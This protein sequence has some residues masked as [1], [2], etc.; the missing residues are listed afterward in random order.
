MKPQ[1]TS[2]HLKHT[3]ELTL[4]APLRSDFVAVPDVMSYTTRLRLVLGTLNDLRRVSIER[5]EIEN[6]GALERLRSLHDVRWSIVNGE[7]QLLLAVTFDRSWEAYIQG[8]V[9]MAGPLLDMIFSHCEGYGEGSRCRD[10][11]LA[12]AKWARDHQVESQFFYAGSPGVTVD[13]IRYFVQQ[14]REPGRNPSD[15]V[16][17]DPTDGGTEVSGYNALSALHELT[18]WFPGRREDKDSDRSLW[19][20]AARVTIPKLTRLDAGSLELNAERVWLREL[21]DPPAPDN[22]ARDLMRPEEVEKL[23]DAVQA[24]VLTKVEATHGLMVLVRLNDAQAARKFLEKVAATSESETS[25]ADVAINIGFTW[26]GLERLDLPAET[27]LEVPK[28]FREGMQA[29]AGLLGD[30]G[31]NSPE[32]WE[33]PRRNYPAGI[34]DGESF[35]LDLV[36]A[37]LILQGKAA[38][39]PNDHAWTKKHPFHAKLTKLLPAKSSGVEVLHVHALR[40]YGDGGH[41][42]FA[43]GT[44]QP[45]PDVPGLNINVPQRDRVP[46]GE[47]V[48]GYRGAR[49]KPTGPVSPF[50]KNGSFLVIRK[51][52]QNVAAFEEFAK[53]NAESLRVPPDQ[54]ASAILGRDRRTGRPLAAPAENTNDFDYENDATGT[55]CPFH[56]HIRRANP[57]STDPNMRTTIP[58]IL[59]RGFTYGSKLADISAANDGDE[60]GLVFMAYNANIANQ[61][62]VV[63]RWINGGNSTG[64]LSAYTDLF[65]GTLPANPNS[66]WIHVGT[67]VEYLRPPR[68]QLVTVRWGLYV[69]VPSLEILAQIAKPK[70][71]KQ[72]AQQVKDDPELELGREILRKLGVPGEAGAWKKVLEDLGLPDQRRALWQA[73]RNEDPPVIRTDYGVLV[74]RTADVEAV[75]SDDGTNFSVE[76]YGSRMEGSLGL[77]HLG[78]D[79]HDARYATLARRPNAFA[80]KFDE[81]EAFKTTYDVAMEI[82]ERSKRP[83]I[84]VERF[85]K[86]VFLTLISTWFGLPDGERSMLQDDFLA[87]SKFVFQ[88]RPTDVL[89][90]LGTEGGNRLAEA[91]FALTGANAAKGEFLAE[92][93]RAGVPHVE[94]DTAVKSLASGLFA[95]TYGTFLAAIDPWIESGKLWRLPKT[96]SELKKE[97]L[98][99]LRAKQGPVVLY[100]ICKRK[101]TL[102][103]GPK[104][105]EVVPGDRIVLGIGSAANDDPNSEFTW[106]FGG[107]Y[108]KQPHACPA[109]PMAIGMMLGLTKAI[110][111]QFNLR[112]VRRFLLT[113]EVRPKKESETAAPKPKAKASNVRKL[114]PPSQQTSRKNRSQKRRPAARKSVAKASVKA[115]SRRD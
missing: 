72:A 77:Q 9:D 2:R 58:R 48:L 17:S 73:I 31:G 32:L 29:R 60:R 6:A 30:T 19:D 64:T 39:K 34:R 18:R 22:E 14:S 57:R 93:I 12:F 61:F 111:V 113:F 7:R 99:A 68:E 15:I 13:D 10:G 53:D 47:F 83:V 46:L 44:S 96:P 33:R 115:R 43:D 100:R 65:S 23:R 112:R 20:A 104:A 94:R 50:F 84:H 38:A 98:R 55:R 28:E 16:V 59:R 62:E 11:Y 67:T 36:D 92:L 109:Q 95:A 81:S 63:Q 42:G 86:E 35:P 56:A 27:L 3:T 80:A 79:A 69:F 114:V 78:I 21:Q 1:A 66:H 89:Q 85:A 97:L 75:L 101:Q 26:A 41:F 5:Y 70:Q 87:N 107:S 40:R 52:Q 90:R 45:V 8:I 51:L 49:P 4:L 110:L 37:V 25:L 24:N 102:G 105:I 103:Q 74:S 82:I 108:Q 91:Y 54:I 88:P 76:E 106:L 71:T